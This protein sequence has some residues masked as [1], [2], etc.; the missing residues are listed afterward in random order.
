MGLKIIFFVLFFASFLG[1]CFVLRPAETPLPPSLQNHGNVTF[2]GVRS[3]SYGIEPFPSPAGWEKAMRTMSDYFEN[4]TPCA[5]WIVGEMSGSEDCHLFFPGDGKEYAYISFDSV[6]RHEEF[7][8]AFDN[9][10]IS[11]FLQVESANANVTTL[12]DLVLGRYGHHP[13]VIGFGVDVEWYREAD[14]PGWGVK[15]DDATAQQWE[16]RVKAH[17]PEYRLFLKHWDSRWMPPQYRGDII[18]VDDGQE[19]RGL[20]SMVDEFTNAW[21]NR[22]YPNIVFFQIGYPSDRPWWGLLTNPPKTIGDAL[23]GRTRQN[24]G[25]FWVD[26]TLR[27][28]LPTGEDGGP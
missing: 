17:G 6:D 4:S 16:A 14:N 2:A 11:V 21:A 10:G 15:V 20:N 24:C 1:L 7:L 3:S 5:I 25:I 22:F 27:E 23:Q 13:C 18:F 26:F 28:T 8:T 19:F 9:M 12:I